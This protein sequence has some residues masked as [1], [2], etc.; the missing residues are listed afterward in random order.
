M[1][2][3]LGAAL[4]NSRKAVLKKNEKRYYVELIH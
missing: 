2:T 1:E 4:L 3:S